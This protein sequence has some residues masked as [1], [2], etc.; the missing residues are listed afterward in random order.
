MSMAG[1]GQKWVDQRSQSSWQSSGCQWLCA[2]S[3]FFLGSVECQGLHCRGCVGRRPELPL[4]NQSQAA[5]K[6]RHTLHGVQ[7]SSDWWQRSLL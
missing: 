6:F 7:S 5:C 4:Q 1:R 3:W 2:R